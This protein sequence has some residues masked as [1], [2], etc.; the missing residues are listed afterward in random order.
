MWA[1]F[2]YN[3]GY[4]NEHNCSY[5]QSCSPF[6]QGK[7]LLESSEIKCLDIAFLETP[8]IQHPGCNLPVKVSFDIYYIYVY[9]QQSKHFCLISNYSICL[10]FLPP[11]DKIQVSK[12]TWLLLSM[13]GG[14]IMEERGLIE[15]KVC[16]L[17]KMQINFKRII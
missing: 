13:K 2:Q 3:D 10:V 7:L 11:D 6:L 12:T 14:Y 16:E 15:V 9:V 4:S 5:L 17:E 8:L 1:T